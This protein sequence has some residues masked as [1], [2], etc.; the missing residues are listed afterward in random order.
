MKL[1][2]SQVGAVYRDEYRVS[3]L[4]KRDK[5]S[6]RSFSRVRIAVEAKCDPSCRRIVARAIHRTLSNYRLGGWRWPHNEAMGGVRYGPSHKSCPQY[7]ASLVWIT[8]RGRTRLAERRERDI[9][10]HLRLESI[11]KAALGSPRSRLHV[12]AISGAMKSRDQSLKTQSSRKPDR[13]GIHR[14]RSGSEMN[15]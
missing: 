14:S 8:K 5:D 1:S 3:S 2:R 15:E 7:T 11:F 10:H 12:R 6:R 13:A 9:M 4:I